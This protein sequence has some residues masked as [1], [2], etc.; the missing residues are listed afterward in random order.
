MNIGYIKWYD[1]SKGWGFLV[2]GYND[3]FLHRSQMCPTIAKHL[4]QGDKVLFDLYEDPKD[5]ARYIA[6]N[7]KLHP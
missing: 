3:V 6:R 7:L 2:S 5:P 1:D 4:K